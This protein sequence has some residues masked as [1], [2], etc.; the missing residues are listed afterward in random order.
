MSRITW[1]QFIKALEVPPINIRWEENQETETNGLFEALQCPPNE[2]LFI[3]AGPGS[4]KTNTLTLKILKLILIDEVDPST[5]L[6]TTFTKKAALELSSRLYEYSHALIQY[7]KVSNIEINRPNITSVR[8]GTIDSI[9]E[10][11]LSEFRKLGETSPV[12]IEN[13]ASVGIMLQCMFKDGRYKKQELVDY[14]SQFSLTGE[15]NASTMA[16]TLCTIKDRISHDFINVEAYLK[17][18]EKKGAHIALDIIKDYKI[19]LQEKGL[20]DFAKLEYA[21]FEAIESGRLDNYLNDLK[22]VLVDEYQDTNPLQEAIYFKFASHAKS[23]NGSITVVGDDDQSLYRFR[24][25]T[26]DLFKKFPYRLKEKVGVQ[27]KTVKL[28]KNYRS[29]QKIIDF[30]NLF[31]N[32]DP[33]FSEARVIDKPP[34]CHT[35][36]EDNNLPVLVIAGK[37]RKEIAITVA[38]LISLLLKEKHIEIQTC[39][40]QRTLFN[41]NDVSE[42]LSIEL[43][44]DC[45]PSDFCLLRFSTKEVKKKSEKF[46]RHLRNELEKHQ[47]KIFNPRGEEI[48]QVQSI[49]TLCGTILLCLDPEC[50]VQDKMKIPKEINEVLNT[51]RYTATLLMEK[52]PIYKGV[53]LNEFIEAWGKRHRL[54]SRKW[55]KEVPLVRLVYQIINWIPELYNDIE[56]LARLELVTRTIDQASVFST[57][58]VNIIKNDKYRDKSIGKIIW[59]VLVPIAAGTVDLEEELLETLPPNRVNVMTIHQSKGLEFPITIVDIGSD[60]T[61]NLPIQAFGR[62]P[63]EPSGPCRIEDEFGAYSET[64]G[65]ER[66]GLFRTFDDLI[67]QYFVAYSRAKDLLILIATDKVIEGEIPVVAYGH[68]RNGTWHG[69]EY[70]RNIIIL[71]QRRN[72]NN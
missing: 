62:F 64:H 48:N 57:Y 50:S 28:S 1:D 56:G 45:S 63:K 54:N 10:D 6:V 8:V 34:I 29:T 7:F 21:L 30:C 72:N 32:L 58:N 3:I 23:N 68:T 17:G 61:G 67:R 20:F 39:T 71:D 43:D 24:G 52:N 16:N 19:N 51:W 26:V 36:S 31:I 66:T 70:K 2:S 13:F 22:Y 60:Y 49:Q 11:L 5:I 69:D 40:S 15:K 33:A 55:P 38:E 12:L 46:C 41:F 65:I 42:K 37:N 47:I 53:G 35:R 25:A 9:A 14:L 44:K 18:T 4:G 59:D 27:A